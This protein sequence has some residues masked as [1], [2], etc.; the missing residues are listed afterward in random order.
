MVAGVPPAWAAEWAVWTTSPLSLSPWASALTRRRPSLFGALVPGC[1][2]PPG[3][4]RPPVAV[5]MRLRAGTPTGRMARK[6]GNADLRPVAV[7][8]QP[9]AGTPA[10]QMAPA[11]R[12]RRPP[13]SSPG[14]GRHARERETCANNVGLCQRDYR[15]TFHA[16]G[17]NGPTRSWESLPV[18]A[19]HRHR[20]PQGRETCTPHTAGCLVMGD[21]LR[22]AGAARQRARAAACLW[23]AAVVRALTACGKTHAAFDRRSIP[24]EPLRFA[25]FCVAFRSKYTRYSSLTR[26]VS[27]A[28]RPHR[29]DWPASALTWVSPQAVT[30]WGRLISNQFQS[31]GFE[32]TKVGEIRCREARPIMDCCSR[33]QAVGE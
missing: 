28:P 24:A 22:P 9:R 33:D 7:R 29:E 21:G 12:E 19:S 18:G 3:R 13:A 10:V 31:G 30:P 26:L 5:K 6:H 15:N 16:G 32:A 1:M 17:V 14:G 2:A 27:R 8:M 20:G 4:E 11:A 23:A 25:P